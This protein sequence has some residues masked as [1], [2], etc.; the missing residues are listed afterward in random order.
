MYH[1]G[2]ILKIYKKQEKDLG[3][4]ATVEMWDENI[5]TLEVDKK[6]AKE[7]KEEDYVLVDYS[8]ILGMT[9][10]QARQIIVRIL[11]DTDFARVWNTY[12]QQHERAKAAA[13]AQVPSMANS[14]LYR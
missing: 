6:V 11:E 10:P 7:L 9:V 8:P 2:K 1:P 14:G 5:L 12:K 13:T 4:Q 3:I